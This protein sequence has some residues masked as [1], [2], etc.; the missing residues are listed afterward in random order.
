[1]M[2]AAYKFI[3]DSG[4]LKYQKLAQLG[5]TKIYDLAIED[6][7]VLEELEDGKTIANLNLD[8]CR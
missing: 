4:N 7:E 2:T 1:M 5:I 6:D 8:G 3:D